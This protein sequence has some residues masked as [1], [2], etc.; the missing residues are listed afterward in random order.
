MS[1]NLFKDLKWALAYLTAR[2]ELPNDFVLAITYSCNSRCRMCNI[3]KSEARPVFPLSEYQKLPADMKEVNLSGG[4]PFLRADLVDLVA[5]LVKQNPQVRIIINSNGFATELISAKIKEI[6]KIKPDIILGF[7]IDG[8]GQLH[9]EV[10]GIPGGFDKVMATIKA[11]KNLG[12]KDLR[13]AYTAGDYNINQMTQVYD[14]SRQLGME[15]TMAAIHNAENYF[16]ISDNKITKLSEFKKEFD[17]LIKRELAT[18]QPKNWSR[19]YFVYALYR[20]LVSHKRLLPNYSGRDNVFID[21]LGDVYPSDVSG[22]KMGNLKDFDSFEALYHSQ[23]AQ[24]AITLERNEHNWMMCTVRS[25]MKRHFFQ[26]VF[27][28]LKSKLFGVK[29]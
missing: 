24:E 27:W 11:V 1:S 20:F 8:I 10:R 28:I 5:L 2:N 25:A 17:I 29:L 16:N 12:V 15:F 14:L 19:A 21:P 9:D 7:S 26:V 22:H 4:E 6:I 23:K 18:W 3:W 13:I